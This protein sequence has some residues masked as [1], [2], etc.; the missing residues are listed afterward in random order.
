MFS[1]ILVPTDFSEPAALALRHACA[2]AKRDAAR[3]ELFTSVF[4]PAVWLAQGAA[5]IPDDYIEHA[6]RRAGED[7]EALAEALRAEGISVRCR[8]SREPPARAICLAAEEDAADL[9]VMGTHGRTGIAHAALGSVA[10]R[11]LRH[12]PCPVMSI[13][14]DGPEPGPIRTIL[15][16][17]DFSTEARAALDWAGELAGA[18]SADLVIAHAVP[19]PFGVGMDEVAVP[20]PAQSAAETAAR[21]KLTGLGDEFRSIVSELVVDSGP[22]DRIVLAAAQRFR[23]DLIVVGTRGRSGLSHVLL[24]STAER[25]VR[26]SP[27]PVVSLRKS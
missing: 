16:A 18:H 9:V 25:I 12:C 3:L 21:E 23:C 19:M 13:R 27:V 26:T 8:V 2:L 11:T 14:G 10:E 22:P 4:V 1:K 24:G 6:A 7:L 5:P 15:V 20:D 17:T